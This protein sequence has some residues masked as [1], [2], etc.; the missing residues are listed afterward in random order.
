MVHLLGSVSNGSQEAQRE[1]S[2]EY[3]EAFRAEP[4]LTA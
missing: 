4:M 3:A 2:M 1:P